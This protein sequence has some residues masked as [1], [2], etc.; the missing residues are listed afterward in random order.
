MASQVSPA[1]L[2]VRRRVALAVTELRTERQWTRAELARRAG[3]SLAT[4][5]RAEGG[6]Q[7]R[8]DTL[9]RLRRRAR[10]P[11]DAITRSAIRAGKKTQDSSLLAPCS[12]IRQCSP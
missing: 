10:C 11:C 12:S 4:V 9:A 3:V 1:A 6:Q 2:D 5:A 8:I 7:I